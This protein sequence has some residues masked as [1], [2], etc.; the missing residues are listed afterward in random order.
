MGMKPIHGRASDAD[1]VRF[2]SKVD[3][4][5]GDDSCWLWR[6]NLHHGYGRFWL[7]GT[8]VFAHKFSLT[9]KLGRDVLKQ[10]GHRCHDDAAVLGGCPGGSGCLHRRCVN[11]AHLEEQSY[12]EN[13]AGKVY[14]NGQSLKTHCPE[15]HPLIPG[16]LRNNMSKR[17]ARGCLICHREQ[18]RSQ[19]R[20][21]SEAYQ[22]LGITQAEYFRKYGRSVRTAMEVLG[23]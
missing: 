16:N 15:G 21:L 22:H 18:G 13:M 10:S 17:G 23:R 2:W 20:L 11:P 7:D 1:L 8:T 12:A 5:G 14:R 9:L 6:G 3:R 19:A 4:S